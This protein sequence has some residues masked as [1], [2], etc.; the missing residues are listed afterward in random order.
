[1]ADRA[2]GGAFD[3]AREYGSSWCSFGCAAAV[4]DP[5]GKFVG[6]SDAMTWPS[7]DVERCCGG[8]GGSSFSRVRTV[9]S[10]RGPDECAF[11]D[12]SA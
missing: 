12:E 10:A 8:D 6:T 3:G 2:T 9:A 1:M 4:L 11:T 7:L 5:T